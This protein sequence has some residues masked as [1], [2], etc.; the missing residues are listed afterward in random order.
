MWTNDGKDFH[1]PCHVISLFL[2][3]SSL[4]GD[5]MVDDN[6]IF[7][8]LSYAGAKFAIFFRYR[9][10]NRYSDVITLVIATATHPFHPVCSKNKVSCAHECNRDMSRNAGKG[11]AT[12]PHDRHHKVS[13]P[14]KVYQNI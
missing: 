6:S 7:S 3:S 5:S 13:L 1:D 8:N 4:C 10:L 14:I 12:L 11:G 2:H 9:F